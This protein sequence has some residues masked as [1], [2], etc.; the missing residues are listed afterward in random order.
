MLQFTSEESG[1][2]DVG[3]NLN[4]FEVYSNPTVMSFMRVA[5]LCNVLSC[6]GPLHLLSCVSIWLKML[7]QLNLLLHLDLNQ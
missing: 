3:E 1:E 7:L 2:Y 4:V 5:L 6:P